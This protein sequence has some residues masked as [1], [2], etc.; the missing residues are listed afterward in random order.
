V[1]AEATSEAPRRR[2]RPEERRAQLLETALEV[3][4]RRG[5]G[6]AGHTEIAE[7]AGVAVS[8][9]FLY[10]K[11]REALV[12]AVLTEVG[13]FY[14][15]L[16]IRIHHRDEPCRDILVEHR[17]AFHDSLRTHPHHAR[18]ALDWS[19][20]IREELWP[21]YIKFIDKLVAN[22]MRTIR[23]GQAAGDVPEGVDPETSA[24][25]LIASAQMTA[26]Q[27]L[28][29]ADPELVERMAE[30]F[31]DAALGHVAGDPPPRAGA[32]RG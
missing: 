30:L 21:R 4:A 10:F 32:E 2:L 6:R 8:T 19:T 29:G 12:D 18:L 22:H 28:T 13:R 9:V 1:T 31:I 24:R 5:F 7:A 25:M 16:A 23:R 17:A 3:F 15:D 27:R 26:Q 20:A 14:L 11:T